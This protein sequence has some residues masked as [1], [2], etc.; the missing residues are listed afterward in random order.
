MVLKRVETTD[1]DECE[2]EYKDRIALTALQLFAQRRRRDELK[3]NMV[4]S[5]LMVCP[6]CEED[7]TETFMSG[8]GYGSIWERKDNEVGPTNGSM[9]VCIGLNGLVYIMVMCPTCLNWKGGSS[10]DENNQMTLFTRMI[11]KFDEDP[12]ICYSQKPSSYRK[13][14]FLMTKPAER[15]VDSNSSMETY[16][17]IKV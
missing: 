3:R 13:K 11:K 7:C 8:F 15:V 5:M 9:T 2:L 4:M 17:W 1:T 10:M 14:F 16:A 6:I 12:Y